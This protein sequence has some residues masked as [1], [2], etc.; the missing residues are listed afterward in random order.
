[1][2]TINVRKNIDHRRLMVAVHVIAWL[3]KS[4][5]LMTSS[6]ISILVNAHSVVVRR[7]MQALMNAG[8][9]ESKIGRDGGYF[10]REPADKITLGDVYSAIN[11]CGVE[12]EAELDASHSDDD[13][14]IDFIFYEIEQETINILRKYTIS[15]VMKQYDIF[16]YSSSKTIELLK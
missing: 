14:C 4:D 11:T 16:L 12:Q 7:I 9:V 8:I 13:S 15:H 10:L 1:M 5:C 3:A 6:S 2:A